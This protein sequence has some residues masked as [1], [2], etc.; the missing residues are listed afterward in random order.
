MDQPTTDTPLSPNAQAARVDQMDQPLE[1]IPPLELLRS[2]FWEILT[3]IVPAVI[4]AFV[5]HQFVAETTVVF[6]QSMEPQLLAR[7][8]LVVEKVTYRFTPPQ[9]G[10][11]VVVTVEVDGANLIKRVVGKPGETVEME[12]GTV[13]V[14]GVPLTEPYVILQSRENSA[15]IALGPTEYFVLGDN[16]PNS[17]DSRQFGPVDRK[18]IVGRAWLRYWPLPLFEFFAN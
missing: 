8:R 6:G 3:V 16:R 1:E 18:V 9:R 12:D 14:N 15:P 2:L 4:L 13:L 10:Q 7:Q 11:M 5:I 17:R